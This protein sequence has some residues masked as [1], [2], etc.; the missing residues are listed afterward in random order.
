MNSPYKSM[1]IMVAFD[2]PTQTKKQR[3]IANNFRRNLISCG[4]T[5]LQLSIYTY[6]CNSKEKA[7]GIAENLKFE[8]PDNGHVTIFFITDKQFGMIKNYYGKA[9]VEIE[10]PGLFDCLE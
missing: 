6:Y 10:Q 3:Q 9:K 5:K 8:V 7:L 4:F 2:L 1:W